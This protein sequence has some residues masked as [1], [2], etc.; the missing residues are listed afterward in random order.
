MPRCW[1]CSPWA[2]QLP[3][4]AAACGLYQFSGAV[5]RRSSP[6]C[7]WFGRRPGG[8]RPDR[9]APPT[10]P[11]WS[12]P[13]WRRSTVSHRPA[14][15][16]TEHRRRLTEGRGDRSARATV[17][18]SAIGA[19]RRPAPRWA[20]RHRPDEAG[21]P[22]LVGDDATPHAAGFS[23][24]TDGVKVSSASPCAYRISSR[25]LF[26]EA[27][28]IRPQ[29]TGRDGG[30]V[31]WGATRSGK[32]FIRS[33]EAPR[34]RPLGA[35]N[36]GRR[37][38]LFQYGGDEVDGPRPLVATLLTVL[39]PE[40]PLVGTWRGVSATSFE[41]ARPAAWGTGSPFLAHGLRLL[42]PCFL[43]RLR[44]C[45][46]WPTWRRPSCPGETA[47]RFGV[48]VPTPKVL[49]AWAVDRPR[50]SSQFAVAFSAK[51]QRSPAR[52]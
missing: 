47:P 34:W 19:L 3:A 12:T 45:G 50:R 35:E 32:N 40:L 49:R 9:S 20:W 16:A 15:S 43:R 6:S 22:V 52:W 4:P 44:R 30:V 7:C 42:I 36:A 39:I 26:H 51:L 28:G 41:L 10:R 11:R 23:C 21:S 2:A 46:R 25:A 1:W 8:R 24:A 48:R 38:R 29:P 5:H 18:F 13:G 33:T 27:E 14:L 37:R 31:T 17:M